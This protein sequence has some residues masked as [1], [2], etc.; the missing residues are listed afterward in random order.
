ME[1]TPQQHKQILI[2]YMVA[3]M[4]IEDWHGVSDA[5]NDLRELEAEYPEL[6]KH[7]NGN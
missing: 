2:Q 6:K 5:C 7:N 3:R 1:V 4:S